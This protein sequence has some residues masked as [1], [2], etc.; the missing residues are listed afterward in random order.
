MI[1]YLDQER[2]AT[3][4]NMT[5]VLQ[6]SHINELKHYINHFI[7]LKRSF[8]LASRPSQEL[9]AIFPR[10]NFL[11]SAFKEKIQQLLLAFDKFIIDNFSEMMR[12]TFV[13]DCTFLELRNGYNL[14]DYSEYM[15]S[16][17]SGACTCENDIYTCGSTDCVK[18]YS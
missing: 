17:S 4:T 5:N 16:T 3:R 6:Y 10:R 2:N 7:G 13:G 12:Y 8:R 1:T 15:H 11:R 9:S 18:Y 14:S